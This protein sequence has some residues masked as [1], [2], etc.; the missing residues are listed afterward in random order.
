MRLTAVDG[1]LEVY[2]EGKAAYDIGTAERQRATILD[3]QAKTQ[4][5]VSGGA[6]RCLAETT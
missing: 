1:A 5:T 3:E 6:R 4:A 2:R